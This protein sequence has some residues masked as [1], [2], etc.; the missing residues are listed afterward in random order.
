MDYI[1]SNQ[2]INQVTNKS[3]DQSPD[4]SEKKNLVRKKKS[5]IM[6][7]KKSIQSI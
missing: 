6:K 5:I 4:F 2:V 3:H 1:I 7:Q